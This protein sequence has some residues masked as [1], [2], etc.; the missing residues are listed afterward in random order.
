VYYFSDQFRNDEIKNQHRLPFALPE[1][2]RENN[3]WVII[4]YFNLYFLF[5][6]NKSYFYLMSEKSG[7]KV[8][9]TSKGGTTNFFK[10]LALS[11]F[12]NYFCF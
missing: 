11:N 4:V 2:Y 10:F 8:H 5:G 1:T 9:F 6:H 12:N 7:C 3:Q